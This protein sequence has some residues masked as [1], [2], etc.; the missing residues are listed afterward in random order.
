M[1]AHPFRA[2]LSLYVAL[3]AGAFLA[4][5]ALNGLAYRLVL[6]GGLR[7]VEVDARRRALTRWVAA[8]LGIQLLVGLAIVVYLLLPAPARVSGLARALPP[9]GAVLGNGLGLQLAV[10]RLARALRA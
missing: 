1:P 10:F 5:L 8:L 9:L 2:V 7:Q 4:A 6:S 3:A